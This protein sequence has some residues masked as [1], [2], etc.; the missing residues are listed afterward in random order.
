MENYVLIIMLMI[1]SPILVK[2]AKI[3]IVE[4]AKIRLLMG[5]LPARKAT[6]FIPIWIGAFASAHNYTMLILQY[7]K[8]VNLVRIQIVKFAKWKLYNVLSVNLDTG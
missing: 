4:I 8:D 2:F 5:A 3:I 7:I 1:K 6:I